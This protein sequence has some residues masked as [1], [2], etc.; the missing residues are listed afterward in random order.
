MESNRIDTAVK[1]TRVETFETDIIYHFPYR[2]ISSL[3]FATSHSCAFSLRMNPRS[4]AV[5][6]RSLKLV[7]SPITNDLLLA[8]TARNDGV[9]T[10]LGTCRQRTEVIKM[11]IHA[12]RLSIDQDHLRCHLR[13]CVICWEAQY[14]ED[15]LG[16]DKLQITATFDKVRVFI[17]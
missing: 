8:E 13:S 4:P 14:Q 12:Q 2:V 3:V 11:G 10:T 5:L 9:F 17:M 16:A 7:P 1:K 6:F 15:R